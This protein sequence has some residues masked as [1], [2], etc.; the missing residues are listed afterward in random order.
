M[1]KFLIFS[2]LI[3]MG[4]LFAVDLVTST[5]IGYPDAKKVLNMATTIWYSPQS[6]SES[7]KEYLIKV[8][9]EWARLNPEWKVNLTV[10]SGTISERM[11]K[12][13]QMCQMGNPPDVGPVDSFWLSRFYDY[14]QPLDEFF[15]EEEIN[16][17]FPTFLKMM[18]DPKTGELKA[19]WLNTDVRVLFYRKDLIP[20]PPKTWNELIKIAK[21]LKS[22]HPEILPLVFP[23]SRAEGC[24]MTFILPL[25]WQQGGKLVDEKGKP[26]FFEG[27]NKE[28]MINVFKLAKKLVDEGV[29]APQSVN[30]AHEPEINQLLPAG[31]IAM[32]LGG[33]WQYADLEQ[34][35]GEEGQK[36]WGMAMIPLIEGAK[37]PKT[38]AG[39]WTFG[40]F[41]KDKEKQA[42]AVRLLYKTWISAYAQYRWAVWGIKPGVP[43]KFVPVRKSV[44]DDFKAMQSENMQVIMELLKYAGLRPGAPIYPTISSELSAA[45]S[46]VVAAG[47][48]PEKVLEKAWK[49]VLRA[50]EKL[51]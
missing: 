45:L 15:S 8:W 42:A 13:L 49:N 22:K 27:E 38:A 12:L 19:L 4:V 37:S 51:K 20:E 28:Y 11:T 16:D 44:Y 34:Y 31:N 18:R 9:A 41:T 14:L 26:I 24:M 6:P 5:T 17:F 50:Y 43:V 2:L 25:F 46:E 23:A 7:M 33:N 48:D 35:I 36:K 47:A 1:R 30:I 3:A 39:G 29:L 10:L 40:V 21:D 32:F